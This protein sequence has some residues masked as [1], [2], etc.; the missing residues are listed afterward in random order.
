[1]T[2]VGWPGALEIIGGTTWMKCSPS[3]ET[4][5]LTQTTTMTILNTMT[6]SR[7]WVAARRLCDY[8]QAICDCV[9]AGGDIDTTSAIV[10]GI[11][12]GCTG[13]EGIPVEWRDAR[14]PLPGWLHL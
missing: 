5:A 11:V 10:G 3:L 1:L 4:P 2:N 12:A 13:L 8:R 7:K 9:R 14:E 6:R